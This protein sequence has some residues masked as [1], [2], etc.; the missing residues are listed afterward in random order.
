LNTESDQPIGMAPAAKLRVFLSYSRKDR[1]FVA[2]LADA[3]SA[4]DYLAD[5]DQSTHH[6]ETGDTG[7][8][9]T[10]D[11]WLRLQDMIAAA[12]VFVLVV[13]P[14][15]AASK[16][17]DEEIAFA[18]SLAKR[19]I[20][21]TCRELDFNSAPPRLAA[22]NV[23]HWFLQQ[24]FD[25]AFALLRS[26]LD[27]DV[28][29]LRASS[30]YTIEAKAWSDAGRA[31]DR[32]LFGEEIA[33]AEAWSARRPGGA[34]QVSELVLGFLS[35]SRSAQTERDLREQRTIRRTRGLQRWIGLA[36]ATAFAI[37]VAG[38]WFVIDGQRTLSRARSV[39]LARIAQQY[40]DQ[41]DFV[42]GLRLAILAARETLMDP[43]T[44]AARSA[45]LAGAQIFRPLSVIE[46]AD[47]L[48]GVT[49][50]SDGS[51]ILAWGADKAVRYWNIS[52]GI[53]DRPALRDDGAVRSIVMSR[54]RTQLMTILADGRGQLWDVARAERI[55]ERHTEENTQRIAMTFWAGGRASFEN[56]TVMARLGASADEILTTLNYA[57]LGTDEAQLS[58][59]GS[60]LITVGDGGVSLND[61]R[62]NNT[63][64]GFTDAGWTRGAALSHDN[65]RVLTWTQ[66][67]DAYVWDISGKQLAAIDP[68][69]KVDVLGAVFSADDSRFLTWSRDNTARLWDASTGKPIGVV[70]QH[71]KAVR[72]G[73]FSPDAASI[74]TW[75][76]D[77][78]ARLW[79]IAEI[80]APDD[81][82]DPDDPFTATD[83]V[84][85][86]W[87]AVFG[88][89][90]SVENAEFSKNGAYILT[91]GNDNAARLWNAKTGQQIGPDLR[92]RQAIRDARFSPDGNRIVTWGADNTII[93][94]SLRNDGQIGPPIAA[95]GAISELAFS[96]D[97]RRILTRTDV[98]Q[99]WD[100]ATYAQVGPD[101]AITNGNRSSIR[102]AVFSADS[103]R[104][105]AW[106]NNQVRMWETD[107][108]KLI[109]N[110]LTRR[111]DIAGVLMSA[112]KSRIVTRNRDNTIRIWDA[113]TGA[114]RAP[115]LN[116]NGLVVDVKF[117]QDESRLLAREENAATV[118]DVETSAS[119]GPPLRHER[120]IS[121][122]VLSA[123]G[124]VVATVEGW[125]VRLWDPVSGAEISAPFKHQ[126]EIKRIAL[127][128]DSSK[129]V[130]LSSIPQTLWD[131]A[132]HEEVKSR[133]LA[134]I[135]GEQVSFSPDGSRMFLW[136]SNS[137]VSLFDTSVWTLI[138]SRP[139]VGTELSRQRDGVLF[140]WNSEA[141]TLLDEET[142]ERLT[143]K[144]AHDTNLWGGALSND[145][146]RL[147]THGQDGTAR[148]WD[149]A[150]A[151][152]KA[153]SN[154][155]ISGFCSSR[156]H[157]ETP[158]RQLIGAALPASNQDPET[159]LRKLDASDVVAAPILAGRE[160][161]DVCAW[162]PPWYDA[163][164]RTTIGWA[165]R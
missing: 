125:S 149:T 123:K 71:Q 12:D 145:G 140:A 31:A 22:L 74:L 37:T 131:V 105:I 156:F 90:A 158:E 47:Q 102:G 107:T 75:S 96:G 114:Q 91:R 46:Y 59:D 111:N 151:T 94:W 85:D 34:P 136:G 165:F 17:V 164:L 162:S 42:R 117:S 61:N 45:L 25:S 13:S 49:F 81:T 80:E 52:T 101:L 124:D 133:D 115:S 60:K 55:G 18:R 65:T 88:H 112:D 73:A 130:I 33:A 66:E 157:T 58:A 48:E 16:V 9:P 4:K 14:D 135:R 54:D 95:H 79:D 15:S 93:V 100:A 72:G 41:G 104:V 63:Y 106:G 78:T 134:R 160:G 161:E 53:E 28:D 5:F 98:V 29:W 109:E 44:P 8:A 126:S 77:G 38:A 159:S 150:W 116:H 86:R 113:T 139:A 26:A 3:L 153:A 119:I 56:G 120:R 10:D 20:G 64:F 40:Y 1:E 68:P 2:K 67:G 43:S 83:E 154:A 121:D 146:A 99:L 32:L 92:H 30:R 50:S 132:S 35:A 21:V 141:G 69:H 163:L 51:H 97:G 57:N 84:R 76:D 129:L 152:S 143:G 103:Q 24:S 138:Y 110:D 142:G 7:I 118:W 137:T 11:W 27:R 128:P 23:N 36:V 147:V 62:A 148:V 108:G 82:F 144:F 127:S 89:G 6:A 87:R 122:A 155:Y 39:M 19:V 70:L